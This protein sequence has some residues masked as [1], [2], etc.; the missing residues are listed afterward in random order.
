MSTAP[1]AAGAKQQPE[2]RPETQPSGHS[3]HELTRKP[4]S[5]S[6]VADLASIL[7]N[8][9]GSKSRIRKYVRAS[10]KGTEC[11]DLRVSPE[12]YAILAQSVAQYAGSLLAEV[13]LA[14]RRREAGLVICAASPP[15][16]EVRASCVDLRSG[17]RALGACSA[18]GS[19]A[20]PSL[21]ASFGGGNADARRA[22]GAGRKG[23]AKQRKTQH[24][25][26]DGSV[27]V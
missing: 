18:G 15:D 6:G 5:V 7:T 23:E 16:L 27:C 9:K 17:M 25:S 26:A 10:L 13:K 21:G 20:Q 1:K 12:A 3:G 24:V 8:G 11:G 22:L 4:P 19:E 2:E 14:A